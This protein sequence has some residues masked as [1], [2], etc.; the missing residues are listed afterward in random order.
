MFAHFGSLEILINSEEVSEYFKKVRKEQDVRY[1][2]DY[3]SQSYNMTQQ[4]FP[5]GA[6]AR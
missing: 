6:A 5:T 2:S 1:F 3:Y 4:M